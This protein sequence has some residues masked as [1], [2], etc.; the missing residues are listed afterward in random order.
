MQPSIGPRMKL[1]KASPSYR[2]RSS[3]HQA[4]IIIV[5]TDKQLEESPPSFPTYM[6][7]LHVF[8]KWKTLNIC[9]SMKSML[10]F[11]SVNKILI[12]TITF[13]F[14]PYELIFSR[15]FKILHLPN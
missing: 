11:M 10:C 4:V 2:I 9:C 5:Q 12:A 1:G 13:S 3:P 14:H 7:A 15:M 6:N 8:N